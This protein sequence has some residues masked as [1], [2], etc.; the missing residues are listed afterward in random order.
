M[1][2]LN[3]ILL[4]SFISEFKGENYEIFSFVEPN[5]LQII[6][7]TNL[8]Y[9]SIDKGKKYSCKIDYKRGKLIVSEILK[10]A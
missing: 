6:R 10:T 3:L 8:K 4:D 2:T 7:G 5:T 9:D 1:F